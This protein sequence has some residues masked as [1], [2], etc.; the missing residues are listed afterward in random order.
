MSV[1]KGDFISFSM[2]QMKRLETIKFLKSGAAAY[3]IVETYRVSGAARL[4]RVKAAISGCNIEKQHRL[5]AV[6]STETINDSTPKPKQ[7]RG[8]QTCCKSSEDLRW[9]YQSNRHLV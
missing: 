8:S 3:L 9:G 2:K 1:R 6:S 5:T 4:Q 7:N